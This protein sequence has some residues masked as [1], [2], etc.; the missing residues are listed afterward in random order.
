MSFQV[1]CAASTVAPSSPGAAPNSYQPISVS[2]G[3][4]SSPLSS[5]PTGRTGPQ[6]SMS[7]IVTVTGSTRRWRA[8]DRR[9]SRSELGRQGRQRGRS[10]GRCLCHGREGS[11]SAVGGIVAGIVDTA[12]GVISSV[13][14]GESPPSRPRRRSTA[15]A[16]HRGDRQKE[17]RPAPHVGTWG[18]GVV[19]HTATW[20][21]GIERR[22]STSAPPAS[23]TIAPAA[24][25][26]PRFEPLAISSPVFTAVGAAEAPSDGDLLR[27]ERERVVV[28]RADG[29]HDEVGAGL[30]GDGRDVDDRVCAGGASFAPAISPAGSSSSALAPL[31]A[32]SIGRVSPT[33]RS[34]AG[35]AAVWRTVRRPWPSAVASTLFSNGVSVGLPSASRWATTV[36]LP[37]RGHGELGHRA[38]DDVLGAGGTDFEV[39]QR[40]TGERRQVLRVARLE[41][42]DD[43]R[44]VDGDVDRRTGDAMQQGDGRPSC[45][46]AAPGASTT[47]AS[48]KT[49]DDSLHVLRNLSVEGTRACARPLYGAAP[50]VGCTDREAR[51]D[52]P[53]VSS[54][55]DS[56][57]SRT[58]AFTRWRSRI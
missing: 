23:I 52:Q 54:R 5:S 1:T 16:G 17:Q 33:T 15:G 51:G 36:Q 38:D 40:L 6:R 12:T 24:A 46:P 10:A 47:A 58:S 18:P 22:R 31:A 20:S 7:S 11:A 9:T 25:S 56:L 14:R 21:A 3:I 26:S 34:T 44:T 42:G 2:S 39:H 32:F 29:V 13:A 28:E 45:A 57:R 27:E 37:G 30:Q 19:G 49:G 50:T 41:A 35:A 53:K 43:D 8:R 48:G 55:A 4:S